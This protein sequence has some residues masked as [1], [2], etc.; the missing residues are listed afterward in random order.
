MLYNHQVVDHTKPR[1]QT[2]ITVFVRLYWLIITRASS[3][4]ACTATYGADPAGEHGHI[5]PV[6]ILA[7]LKEC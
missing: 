6:M 7:A 4:A 2:A 5:C 3:K 1:L